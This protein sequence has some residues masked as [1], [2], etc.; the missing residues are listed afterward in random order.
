[1][2]LPVFEYCVRSAHLFF[3]SDS[4][5][6]STFFENTT[7]S[8]LSFRSPAQLREIRFINYVSLDSLSAVFK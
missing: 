5:S 2:F 7:S 6:H 1:M 4:A 8:S 3:E